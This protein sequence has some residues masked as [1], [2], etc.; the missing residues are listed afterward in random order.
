MARDLS[1]G[2]VNLQK[3]KFISHQQAGSLRTGFA[4]NGDVLFTHKGTIGDVALLNCNLDFVVL[5]PQVTGY[6]ILDTLVLDRIYLY[7]LLKSDFFQKQVKKIANI[8]STRAYIGITRQKEL[9]ICV[10][11]ID[12]QRR[13]VAILKDAEPEFSIIKNVTTRKLNNYKNLKSAILK[14]ELQSEAK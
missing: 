8:G 4:K 10:P 6:R 9:K 2:K 14:N 5:T 13:I 3:C 7:F 12:I 1:N 11:P